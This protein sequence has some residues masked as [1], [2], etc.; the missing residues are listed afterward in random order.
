LHLIDVFVLQHAHLYGSYVNSKELWKFGSNLAGIEGHQHTPP[1]AVLLMQQ[2]QAYHD[3]HPLP[4]INSMDVE[5]IIAPS[6]MGLLALE[7]EA[8]TW[9][10]PVSGA[11]LTL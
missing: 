9:S 4:E 3:E 2:L 6:M 8:W 11:C 1:G 5:R 7:P 10:R